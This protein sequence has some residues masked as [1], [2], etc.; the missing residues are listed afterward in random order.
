METNEK[1][2]NGE[3]K[4][5]AL[6]FKDMFHWTPEEN[7]VTILEEMLDEDEFARLMNY[8]ESSGLTKAPAILGN[9]INGK[10]TSSLWKQSMHIAKMLARFTQKLHISWENVRSPF[11]IGLFQGAAIAE[12]CKYDDTLGIWMIRDPHRNSAD[13]IKSIIP[14]TMEEEACLRYCREERR[15][16]LIEQSL[17]FRNILW[18]HHACMLAMLP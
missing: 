6:S 13:I 1:Q 5:N 18:A 12:E 17:Q 11:V 9:Q 16:V 7:P 4:E 15:E 8:A 2:T 10:S 3:I 14:L